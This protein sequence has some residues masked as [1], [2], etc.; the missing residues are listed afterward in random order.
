VISLTYAGLYRRKICYELP[1][2]KA[3]KVTMQPQLPS[4]PPDSLE[5][6]ILKIALALLLLVVLVYANFKLY[7]REDG[8]QPFVQSYEV[9]YRAW[10]IYG[11]ASLMLGLPF[12]A[13]LRK[14]LVDRSALAAVIT[15]S[16]IFL[17]G[18]AYLGYFD[19][20]E[21]FDQSVMRDVR[22]QVTDKQ[23][24][25]RSLLGGEGGAQAYRLTLLGDWPG[26]PQRYL[27]VD[28]SVFTSFNKGSYLKLS[29][30]TGFLGH[31]WVPAYGKE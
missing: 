15:V 24:V 4:L 25:A 9:T 17:P 18:T 31:E 19:I 3:S 21:M 8:W 20:N 29:I 1:H 6:T 13:W 7:A 22:A 2:L 14:L 23:T 16:A 11:I 10:R 26:T 28:E 5:K 27:F 30:K 12:F